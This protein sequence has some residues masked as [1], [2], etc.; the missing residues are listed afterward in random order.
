MNKYCIYCDESSIDNKENPFMVIG[1]VFVKEEYKNEIKNKINKL[2]KES[3]YYKEIKWNN[4][5][6][7]T[8]FLYKKIIDVFFDYDA[9][10]FSFHCIKIERKKV[11]YIDYH[12]NDPEKGFYK[13]YYQLLKN[14]FKNNTIYKIF[15][16]YKPVKDK[17]RVKILKFFWEERVGYYA[18]SKIKQ[19]ISL[20]SSKNL[21]IQTADLFAGAVNNA[22][23]FK[24][25]KS[26]AKKEIINYISQKLG[27]D[28]LKFH[29]VLSEQKFNI[30]YINL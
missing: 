25:S 24:S 4:T 3:Y 14:K 18:N 19:V 12:D 5:T 11:K 29:S 15:L 2:K 28:D 1:C 10:I 17:N 21:F 20:D 9:E 6:N 27:K 16:D 26:E 30:F 22:I 8:I 23:N 13:F 7:R